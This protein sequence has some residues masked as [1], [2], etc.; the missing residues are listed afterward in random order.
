MLRKSICLWLLGSRGWAGWRWGCPQRKGVWIARCSVNGRL[1]KSQE[2]TCVPVVENSII[3]K[4]SH[5]ELSFSFVSLLNHSLFLSLT[6]CQRQTFQ[7]RH[8]HLHGE[9]QDRQ[10]SSICGA[11]AQVRAVHWGEARAQILGK[12]RV[13]SGAGVTCYSVKQQP[14]EQPWSQYPSSHLDGKAAFGMS[15]TDA[16]VAFKVPENYI[17]FVC[18]TEQKKKWNKDFCYLQNDRRKN[19][20]F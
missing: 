14:G 19:V 8:G 12:C 20:L 4:W 16:W 10:H 1:T 17:H 9:K 11:Q 6:L 7:V 3:W 15:K 13:S 18:Q 5:S 2:L